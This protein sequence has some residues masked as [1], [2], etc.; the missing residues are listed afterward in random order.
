[1]W[2]EAKQTTL[3]NKKKVKKSPTDV[4]LIFNDRR[5]FYELLYIKTLD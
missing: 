3:T 5:T 2:V 1:M 4:V